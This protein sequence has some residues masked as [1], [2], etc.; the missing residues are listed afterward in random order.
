MVERRQPPSEA[1]L[2]R[3]LTTLGGEISYP[4]TPALA[5][6]V[7]Q[8]LAAQPSPLLLRRPW[9]SARR[10][11]VVL[12]ALVLAVVVVLIA[13]PNTRSALAGR[14]G[15]PGIEIRQVPSSPRLPVTATPLAATPTF[16]PGAAP[17]RLPTTIPTLAPLA[18]PP[19]GERL[20]LGQQKTLTAAQQQVSFPILLPLQLG[21]PDAIYVG[22]APP[23]GEVTLVYHPRAGLPVTTETGVGL[24]LG[25]FQGS[26]DQVFLSKLAGP[27]TTISPAT[28]AGQ[29]G[30]WLTGQPHEVL[31]QDS[32]GVTHQLILRLA[33][34]TLIWTHGALTLRIESAL[35]EQDALTI[36][37]T[38]R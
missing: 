18:T 14:L 21:V 10:L 4:P 2:E 35:S 32:G 7:R 8:R 5:G 19:L 17:A 36:A 25:E 12:A 24:L 31:Y 6:R 27:G 9:L 34:N 33:G 29:P 23:G 38:L 37:N 20:H 22:T 30:F 3:L 26:T 15:L 16:V 13:F 11:V 1:D 28:V